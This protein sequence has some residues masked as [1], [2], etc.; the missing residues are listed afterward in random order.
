[1]QEAQECEAIL[2]NSLGYMRRRRRGLEM[3]IYLGH[4]AGASDLRGPCE[5]QGEGRDKTVEVKSQDTSVAGFGHEGSSY[6]GMQVASK[7]LKKKKKAR[8]LRPQ[9]H[10]GLWLPEL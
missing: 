1:M 8:F 6:Q 7:R 5:R 3:E 10:S 4:L 9:V 2:E